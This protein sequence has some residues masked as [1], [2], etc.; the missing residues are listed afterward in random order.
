MLEKGMPAIRKHLSSLPP[1]TGLDVDTLRSA[2]DKAERAFPMP[3]GVTVRETSIGGVAA[4]QL[5]PAGIEPQSSPAILYLHGGGYALGSPKSHRHM[6]AALCKAAGA[7]GQVIHYRRAPEAPFP[8]AVDDA[9]AAYAAL[10]EGGMSAANL[11]IAGDSAGG[12]LTAATLVAL[13][14]RGIALP[15]AGICISP[16]ADLTNSSETYKTLA[17]VDPMVT[18]ADIERWTA[19]YLNGADPKTP[20]ASPAFADLRGLPP[21]LIQ[22]GSDEVLLGD[23]K[24]LAANAEAA[25]VSVTLEVWENMIHVWHWFGSY[26]DEAAEATDAAAAFVRKNV[27]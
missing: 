25:G 8:A 22:V 5:L 9:V 14:D 11:V 26:L 18:P 13:R 19:A 3:D 12:G 6:V 15:A 23:S 16:W 7:S 10:L 2:Y 4:E 1:S 20:L 21:L 24:L 27:G 17:D